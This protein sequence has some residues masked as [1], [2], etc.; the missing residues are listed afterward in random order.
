[1]RRCVGNM[2][3]NEARASPWRVGKPGIYASFKASR[4]DAVRIELQTPDLCVAVSY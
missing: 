4:V 2:V 1:M 3:V